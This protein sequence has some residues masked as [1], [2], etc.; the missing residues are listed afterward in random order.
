MNSF[1]SL[2]LAFGCSIP[3]LSQAQFGAGVSIASG[4]TDV[5]EIRTADLNGD[6]ILDVIIRQPNAIGWFQNDGEGSFAAFDTIH[7]SVGD[8]GAFDIGDVHGDDLSDIVLSDAG[9][10]AILLL[11]NDGIGGFGLPESIV[12]LDGGVVGRL[13]LADVFGGPEPELF[14]RSGD[15]L[16]RANEGG[17]FTEAQVITT[18]G[19]FSFDFQVL[20]MDGDGNLDMANFQGLT[21]T[22]S[23]WL[24][25]GVQGD[26]WLNVQSGSMGNVGG[27]PTQV[28]DVDGDGD[29]DLAN[30]GN[31]FMQWWK[32]PLQ[33]A[34]PYFL[35]T[36]VD[37]NTPEFFRR[38]YTARLGC[39]AGA[40]MVW[41]DSIGEQVEWATYDPVLEA[42]GP[43]S[44]LPG[45]PS[46]LE[47]S[48]GDLDG[49]GKEDLVL[50]HDE[51]LLSW[52]RSSI[53]A[54][55]ISV[56]TEPFDTLCSSGSSYA[57]V[58]GLP[59][60]GVWKGPGVAENE[61]TPTG[62]GAFD[63]FYTV[64][65]PVSG[66][67]VSAVQVLNV[68]QAPIV[69][70]VSG[71]PTSNCD[72][73]PLV[74]SASPAGGTWGGAA[75]ETGFVDRSCAVRPLNAGAVYT[76]N[77]VNG[78]SCVGGGALLQLPACTL[79][80]LGPDQQLCLDQ[81]ML[82][83]V[84]QGPNA[85]VAEITGFDSVVSSSPF[86]ATGFFVPGNGAGVYEFIGSAIAPSSCPALDTL[87]VEV[88]P[89]PVVE[90]VLP[91]ET[92]LNTV[93]N[94]DL[95]G[96]SVSGGFYTLDAAPEPIT[97]INPSALTIGEHTITYTYEDP[98]TGCTNSAVDTFS[99]ETHT[100]VGLQGALLDV[101]VVPNPAMHHCQV[102]F[103]AGLPVNV[104]LRDAV[105]RMVGNW[106]AVST[107]M[108]MDLSNFP[109]GSYVVYIEQGEIRGHVKLVVQ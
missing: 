1:H 46:F 2:F 9:A 7:V 23:I 78:G 5:R 85:G 20:D 71:D 29:M 105:G 109:A 93:T 69:T 54:S 97:T 43:V 25:P 62:E 27:S 21:P 72:T 47:I 68:L 33:G 3:A 58:D 36:L 61:F 106:S 82:E 14:Y 96:G 107:P 92:I 44:I 28:L 13:L 15:V 88:S 40:S 95:S 91:F 75:A 31:H 56:T 67:P 57:L 51:G 50:W 83:V 70:L 35:G 104:L 12:S 74:Y 87:L 22:L 34:E 37:G 38:G 108:E 26:P 30:A 52:Y 86:N 101:K 84:L 79:L 73:S 49:D 80:D 41:T 39:G 4:I 103:P 60:G 53:E 45:L 24:N 42:F 59:A 32:F 48:A 66:C 16:V 65:D 55:S 11:P 99:V 81:D 94:V 8:L 77:A 63:L 102:W 10:N 100:S 89:L 6:G 18:S 90:L 64:P 19:G 76:M 98:I 17:S